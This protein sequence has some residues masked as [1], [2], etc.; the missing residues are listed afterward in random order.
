M[1]ENELWRFVRRLQLH[2]SP[3]REACDAVASLPWRLI[4]RPKHSYV[5]REGDLPKE[6]SVLVAGFA[7]RQKH[8]SEG[9]RQIVSFS[10][11][12]D[13]LDFDCLFLSEPDCS[14]QLCVDSTIACVRSDV[15]NALIDKQPEVSRA[16][17]ATLLADAAIFREWVVNTGRRDARQ[18]IAH[19]LCEIL[20]R[21][22]AQEL[23]SEMFELPF[24]QEQ[25]ADATGLT[26]VHVNRILRQ[27]TVEGAIRRNGRM[28]TVPDWELLQDIADFDPRFLHMHGSE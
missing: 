1:A 20:V 21:A 2:G 23:Y 22:R 4:K 11:A 24:T 26:S 3:S 8:M 12:G 6:A 25:I 18:R 16:I 28:I 5:L 7:Q 27:L 14:V 17:T 15:I 9:T 13:P 19:L 10:I